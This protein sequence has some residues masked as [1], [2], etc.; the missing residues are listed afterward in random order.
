[1]NTPDSELLTTGQAAKFCGVT[2][3]AVL[4]WIRKGKLDATR[5]AGGHFRIP[6]RNLD[7][8]GYGKC[9]AMDADVGA[10]GQSASLPRHC[11]EYFCRSESPSEKCEKCVVYRAR[12][13]KCYEVAELGDTIGH[14]GRFCE[15]T[16]ENCS[17]FRACKGL[18]MTVLVVT[19]DEALIDRL[20]G[21]A[22]SASLSLRFARGGYES[23]MV[24]ETFRPA[25]A[26]MD[27]AIP[28]VRDGRLVDSML[29]DERI[30]GI[31]IIVAQRKGD[32]LP[33]DRDLLVITAPFTAAKIE[34]LIQSLV[35][36]T[37]AAE[38]AE[39]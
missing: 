35:P 9:E 16:C 23:S 22:D 15:A 5:T 7:A 20:T 18:A 27:S 30:P 24:I 32:R 34:R 14:E 11:W 8:L 17:F 12:I 13:E 31:R 37:A 38:N 29:Q 1:M 33:A 3:D 19:N 10:M 25:V 4:K 39:G 2:P 36:A 28:E 26:V 6:R 21:Q